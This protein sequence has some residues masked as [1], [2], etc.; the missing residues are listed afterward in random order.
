MLSRVGAVTKRSHASVIKCLPATVF[1]F[2]ESTFELGLSSFEAGPG[3]A[4]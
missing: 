2:D 3:E 1:R 4:V